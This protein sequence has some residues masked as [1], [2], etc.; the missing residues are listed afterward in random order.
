M[1]LEVANSSKY[2]N[3]KFLP[4]QIEYI[5]SQRGGTLMIYEGYVYSIHSKNNENTR[6]RCRNRRCY[7]SVTINKLE[8]VI[9]LF[10]HS[11]E[12]ENSLIDV[13]KL[14]NK[15]KERAVLI[16]KKAKQ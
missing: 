15:I 3:L 7:G 10:P 16:L 9:N 8:V 4:M 13:L 5:K 2:I 11:H 12:T 6:F 1:G 14:K